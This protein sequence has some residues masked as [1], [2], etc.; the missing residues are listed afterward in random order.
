LGADVWASVLLVVVVV[1]SSRG[2]MLEKVRLLSNVDMIANYSMPIMMGA[3]CAVL[4]ST[5]L[6][7]E[8][9]P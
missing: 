5:C 2:H 6:D 9:G 1:A 8:L 7:C 3:C 4:C